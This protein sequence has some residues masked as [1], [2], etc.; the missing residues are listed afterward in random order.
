MEGL[1]RLWS[2][3]RRAARQRDLQAEM[4]LHFELKVQEH[5]ARGL[6]PDQARRQA[7]LDFGNMH[8]AA[9]RSREMWGFVQLDNLGRD[10][11]YGVR[12]FA[13]HPGFTTIVVLTLAL[14]IGANSAIFSV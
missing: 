13:R 11:V 1:H 2:W 8:L 6:T 10:V 5:I 4:H 3:L 9:E 7:R 14:G 12:Q